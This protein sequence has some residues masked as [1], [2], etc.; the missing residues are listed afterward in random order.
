MWYCQ[1]TLITLKLFTTKTHGEY[2]SQLLFLIVIAWHECDFYHWYQCIVCS[3]LS[4]FVCLFVLF[5]FIIALAGF[6]FYAICA[7]QWN[8]FSTS[9]ML[10]Y[11]TCS[12]IVTLADINYFI[13]LTA[14]ITCYTW[15]NTCLVCDN[16]FGRKQFQSN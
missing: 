9:L 7:E 14:Y 12:Y 5:L 11:S 6:F 4:S 15:S 2:I 3:V 1:R 8:H 16:D 13:F 10:R